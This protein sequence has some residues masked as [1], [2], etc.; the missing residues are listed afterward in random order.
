MP[1]TS[2]FIGI[3]LKSEIFT[4]LF[5]DLKKY[6]DENKIA[7]I[8][9]LQNLESIHLTLYYLDKSLDKNILSQIKTDL[10][11]LNQ[12]PLDLSIQC[13]SLFYNPDTILFHLFPTKQFEILLINNMF[14]TKYPNTVADNEYLYQSHITLFKVLSPKDFSKYES[15]ITALINSHVEKIKSKNIF[16]SVN[17]FSVDSHFSPH[18]QTVIA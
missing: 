3:K 14:K 1:I 4:N 13:V 10:K 2:H 12:K 16:E 9:V 7:N 5:K 8:V 17:L 18:K 6:F 11:D 15:E